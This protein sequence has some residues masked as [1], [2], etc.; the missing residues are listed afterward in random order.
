ME[1]FGLP[2]SGAQ[3]TPAWH[4]SPNH[5]E[6]KGCSRPDLVVLHYTAMECGH[7]A[8]RTLCN[9]ETQ[10]SAHYL[11]HA[12][13]AVCQL[14]EEQRRAWHAGAG[15]WG[16]VA[17]VNSRSIGIELDNTGFTPFA[18]AQM[19]A[20]EELLS[21]ILGRWD[22][23]A[24]NVIAHSDLAPGRKIDPGPR[25]DWQRLAHG[26]LSIWPSPN[27]AE[28]APDPARFLSDLS[29]FGYQT[30][31]E[32]E[33]ILDAFRLRFRPAARVR[34]LE[35]ADMKLAAALASTFPHRTSYTAL[36]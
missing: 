19:D 31:L 6:R 22:I 4:P 26:G 15:S 29:T 9:P 12:D 34:A 21:D 11:I 14:V 27:C 1:P 35:I 33:I 36:V 2:P 25:F 30:D 7:A 32:T 13:G 20:L 3:L 17:D 10:V 16:G 18:A 28:I 8:I 23:P 24:Q 5:G